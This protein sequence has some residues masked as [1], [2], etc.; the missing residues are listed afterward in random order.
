MITPALGPV[1]TAAP[2]VIDGATYA[3]NLASAYVIG[4][5]TLSPGNT[6]TLN[7]GPSETVAS[8]TTDARGEPVVI[9]DG[10]AGPASSV[11]LGGQIFTSDNAGAY[12]VGG[13]TLTSGGTITLNPGP[14]QTVVALTTDA[15]GAPVVV[16][17][18]TAAG[19]PPPVSLMPLVVGGTTYLPSATSA[20]VVD[21]QTLTFGGSIIL[22]ATGSTS[23]I[24]LTTNPAGAPVLIVN[25][26]EG[27][28]TATAGES[29]TSVFEGAATAR[30]PRGGLGWGGD[31]FRAW[32]A[33]ALVLLGTV[34]VL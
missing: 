32:V 20:Y 10:G 28:P 13:Q 27:T 24:V 19:S 9:I 2:L 25:A 21:G 23:N 22:S 11:T 33:T 7:P 14:S 26:G 16:V 18:G 8:L 34:I 5:Q 30:I 4:S 6:I 29:G 12:V 1:P 31:L 3:A 15:A 17:D